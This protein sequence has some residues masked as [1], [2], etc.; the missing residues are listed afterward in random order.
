MTERDQHPALLDGYR[1]MPGWRVGRL[2]DET[3]TRSGLLVPAG[4]EHTEQALSLVDI[5]SGERFWAIPTGAW[6]F[7]WPPT[8]EVVVAVRESQIIAQE[9]SELDTNGRYL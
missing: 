3:K 5:E 8:G 7:L 6:R 2:V 4:T 9:A 1:V